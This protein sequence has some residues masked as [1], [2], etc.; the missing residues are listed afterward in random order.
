MMGERFKELLQSQQVELPAAR[1]LEQQRTQLRPK[2]TRIV[3]QPLER[4]VGVLEFLH[5]RQIA[6]AFD[7]KH[8]TLRRSFAP[9]L[10]GRAR[11]ELVIGIVDL[12]R[13]KMSRIE[14]QVFVR[15]QFVRIEDLLPMLVRPPRGAD[16][17]LRHGRYD[18]LTLI[19][20]QPP[21]P[22]GWARLKGSDCRAPVP[23]VARA[24]SVASAPGA[25]AKLPCQRT[26]AS[27]PAA[28]SI[29]VAVSQVSPP[30]ALN[31]TCW[32]PR[33]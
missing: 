13:W 5:V 6:T 10:E 14:A 2:S 7:G 31:S 24:T 32:M 17:G 15:R 30:S 16:P 21:A 23:S 26:Q 1:E 8:E 27:R 19:V 28:G 12:D 29:S 4:L 20:F 3:Q 11:R 22:S 9:V 33:S 25:M 18:P